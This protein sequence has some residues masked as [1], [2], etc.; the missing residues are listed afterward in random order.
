MLSYLVADTVPR[1]KSFFKAK[2]H[3]IKTPCLDIVPKIR[4]N[5]Y[6]LYLNIST[7][8]DTLRYIDLANDVTHACGRT[9]S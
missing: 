9:Y 3:L 2:T 1:Y 8:L 4:V 6:T 5:T 7:P